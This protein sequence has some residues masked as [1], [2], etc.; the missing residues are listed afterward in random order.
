MNI[1]PPEYNEP[2]LSY[3]IFKNSYTG[4]TNARVILIFHYNPFDMEGEE[5]WMGEGLFLRNSI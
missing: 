4:L 3:L 2:T 5:T 1:L